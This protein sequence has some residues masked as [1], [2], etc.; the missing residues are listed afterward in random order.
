MT[1]HVSLPL[2]LG[3][4]YLLYAGHSCKDSASGFGYNWA[5]KD[6]VLPDHAMKAYWVVREWLQPYITSTLG[7]GECDYAIFL[8]KLTTRRLENLNPTAPFP[9]DLYAIT[10][11][12]ISPSSELTW[13]HGSDYTRRTHKHVHST[14]TSKKDC[15][16]WTKTNNVHWTLTGIN[17]KHIL[18]K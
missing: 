4:K 18:S 12:I 7:R 13:Y 5:I 14:N 16:Q 15:M 8:V 17:L 9:V 1:E 10:V 6:K 2:L 11:R 3:I